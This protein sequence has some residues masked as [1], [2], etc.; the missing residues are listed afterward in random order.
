MPRSKESLNFLLVSS[1]LH[2]ASEVLIKTVQSVTSRLNTTLEQLLTL[3]RRGLFHSWKGTKSD[4]SLRNPVTKLSLEEWNR[5][6]QKTEDDCERASEEECYQARDDLDVESL[7]ITMS[8]CILENSAVL[9]ENELTNVQQILFVNEKLAQNR[10]DAT[11]TEDMFTS[12]SNDLNQALHDMSKK[13]GVDYYND[14]VETIQK[15]DNIEPNDEEARK[16][17]ETFDK[18]NQVGDDI[19]CKM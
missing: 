11:L 1:L 4:Q 10:D 17:L 15:L 6:F 3:R 12:L 8:G 19:L 18:D 7:T 9:E 13:H 5:M 14:F 2:V 16:I